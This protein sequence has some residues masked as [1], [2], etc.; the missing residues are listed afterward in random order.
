MDLF[1]D[2]YYELECENQIDYY[3]VLHAP[4]STTLSSHIITPLASL[5]ILYKNENVVIAQGTGHIQNASKL[6]C[7]EVQLTSNIKKIILE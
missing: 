5:T 4:D 3:K 6:Y 2:K 7:H 1:A